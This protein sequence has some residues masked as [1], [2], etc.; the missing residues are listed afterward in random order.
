MLI[1]CSSRCLP[2]QAMED[3]YKKFTIQDK[4]RVVEAG[5]LM[6]IGTERH[7]SR[8]IDNQLRGRSGRCGPFPPPPPPSPPPPP[9]PSRY[10]LCLW[11]QSGYR[12][13]QDPQGFPEQVDGVLTYKRP[14]FAKKVQDFTVLFPLIVYYEFYQETRDKMVLFCV[15]EAI[16]FSLLQ[17]ET[18]RQ[19]FKVCSNALCVNP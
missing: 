8:R 9:P 13:V 6:V 12:F 1:K 17:E 19:C 5:G 4:A 11:Y 2:A 3:E 16:I 18:G 10:M 7:E 14:T 15:K